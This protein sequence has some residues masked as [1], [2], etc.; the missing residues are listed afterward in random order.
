VRDLNGA[1]VM[2]T[3][4]LQYLTL[5]GCFISKIDCDVAWQLG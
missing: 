3:S 4:S 1:V 2:A 5:L